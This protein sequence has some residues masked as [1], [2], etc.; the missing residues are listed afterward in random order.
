VTELSDLESR[1]ALGRTDPRVGV[2]LDYI[3]QNFREDLTLL[4]LARLVGLCPHHVCRLFRT[5]LGISPLR[6]VKLIRFRHAEE[7]VISS[8]KSIKEVM[9]MVGLNDLSHFVRDFE[10]VVGE[11]PLRHRTRTR[12]CDSSIAQVESISANEYKFTPTL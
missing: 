8:T 9:A 2:I 11:S 5:H 6:C 7:L 1:L 3:S 10:S 4:H 12:K